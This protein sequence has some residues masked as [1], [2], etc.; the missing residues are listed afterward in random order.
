[1][2]SGQPMICGN[3]GKNCLKFE[4][5]NGTWEVAGKAKKKL[6]TISKSA[7]INSNLVFE[8]GLAICYDTTCEAVPLEGDAVQEDFEFFE[9]SNIVGKIND[10]HVFTA[11]EEEFGIYNID[12]GELTVLPYYPVKGARKKYTY[13]KL[14]MGNRVVIW[15]VGGTVERQVGNDYEFTPGYDYIFMDLGLPELFW[16][17]AG[18]LEVGW[19]FPLLVTSTNEDQLFL[20]GGVIITGMDEPITNY[21]GMSYETETYTLVC[22]DYDQP[23]TCKFK[24]NLSTLPKGDMEFGAFPVTHE[25]AV[26]LCPELA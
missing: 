20:F 24:R 21:K 8:D 16:Q 22:E 18:V 5:D 2:V 1:M 9:E 19:A 7:I 26:H 12:T 23:L 14:N 17:R 13:S 10:T 15:I 11:S 3:I 6:T 25:Q 4:F